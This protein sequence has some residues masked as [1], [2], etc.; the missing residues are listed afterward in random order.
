MVTTLASIPCCVQEIR[1]LDGQPHI[2]AVIRLSGG[3]YTEEDAEAEGI[4]LESVQ[5]E[6]VQLAPFTPLVSAC[7]LRKNLIHKFILHHYSTISIRP[8]MSY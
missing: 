2:K 8:N 5:H 4:T 7:V 1:F 3:L 6:G